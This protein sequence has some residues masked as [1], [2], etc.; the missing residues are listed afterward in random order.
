MTTQHSDEESDRI[1]AEGL[2]AAERIRDQ[3][4]VIEQ[5]KGTQP[6]RLAKARSDAEQARGWALIED[7]WDDHVTALPAHNANGER[8]R[9]FTHPALDHRTGTVRR[10]VVLRP[11]RLRPRQRRGRRRHQPHVR[12]GARR[13]RPRHDPHVLGADDDCHAG[14]PGTAVPA[15]STR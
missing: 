11:A 7:A 15:R 13:H 1:I 2:S 6:A 3:I 10:T 5:A 9:Q 12:D 14:R 4:K 8:D